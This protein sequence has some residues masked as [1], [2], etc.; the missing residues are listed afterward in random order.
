MYETHWRLFRKL[1]LVG[2]RMAPEKH[3]GG[4]RRVCDESVRKFD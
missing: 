2:Q 3:D 4:A 1:E